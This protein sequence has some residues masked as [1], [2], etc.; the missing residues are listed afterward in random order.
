MKRLLP[1]FAIIAVLGVAYFAVRKTHQAAIA[2]KEE[3]E[4]AAAIAMAEGVD[5]PAVAGL[6][7]TK[8]G[9]HLATLALL[10]DGKFLAVEISTFVNEQE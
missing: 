6:Y 4:A 3:A 5:Y 1:A 8:P 9:T 2:G 10:P 7:R